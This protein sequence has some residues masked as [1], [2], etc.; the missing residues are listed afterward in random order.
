VDGGYSSR[1]LH[2]F[3]TGTDYWLLTSIDSRCYF[4][5]NHIKLC[6]LKDDM[7]R[8]VYLGSVSLASCGWTVFKLQTRHEILPEDASEDASILDPETG[9]ALASTSQA[10][11][12]AAHAGTQPEH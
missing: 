3:H 5:I 9:E 6:L 11:Q 10:A 2:A 4:D 8:M 7:T 12:C 1:K